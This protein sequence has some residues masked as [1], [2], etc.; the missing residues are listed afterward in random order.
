[1]ALLGTAGRP[2]RRPLPKIPF[3]LQGPSGERSCA[4]E[5][6]SASK[7]RLDAVKK[8]QRQVVAGWRFLLWWCS[9]SSPFVSFLRRMAELLRSRCL[10]RDAPL[11]FPILV[12]EISGGEI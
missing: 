8:K 10:R 4:T 1:V 3:Y 12:V 5:G 7:W 11:E 9:K 6:T 2:R